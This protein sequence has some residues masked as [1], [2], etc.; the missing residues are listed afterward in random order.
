MPDQSGKV[1]AIPVP[2]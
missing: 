2:E 1:E